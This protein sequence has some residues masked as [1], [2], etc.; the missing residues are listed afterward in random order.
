MSERGARRTATD[1]DLRPWWAEVQHLRAA[2][3]RR[4]ARERLLVTRDRGPARRRRAGDD[5]EARGQA[6]ES[7]RRQS[8]A[9]PP[10]VG[11]IDHSRS[12]E[13]SHSR[14]L[15][16]M[17]YSRSPGRPDRIRPRRSLRVVEDRPDRVAMWVPMMGFFLIFVAAVSSVGPR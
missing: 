5:A 11:R 13:T 6:P 16:Q 17:D 8:A 2:A 15:A 14:P 10:R 4:Q 1:A 12:V 3:E 9:P 7:R